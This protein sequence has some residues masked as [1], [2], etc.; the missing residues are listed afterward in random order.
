MNTYSNSESLLEDVSSEDLMNMNVVA[1]EPTPPPEG[2]EDYSIPNG[3][4]FD[5]AVQS[6]EQEFQDSQATGESLTEAFERIKQEYPDFEPDLASVTSWLEGFPQ[7]YPVDSQQQLVSPASAFENVPPAAQT[8]TPAERKALGHLVMQGVLAVTQASQLLEWLSARP[9]Y[10]SAGLY[11]NQNFIQNQGFENGLPVQNDQLYGMQGYNIENAFEIQGQDYNP[12]LSIGDHSVYQ[13]QMPTS[14]P[15]DNYSQDIHRETPNSDPAAL[16]FLNTPISCFQPEQ[17][18]LQQPDPQP[19]QQLDSLAQML[20][21]IVEFLNE[22]AVPSVFQGEEISANTLETV[23]MEEQVEQSV[24]A[25][26]NGAFF[27][28]ESGNAV[29]GQDQGVVDREVQSHPEEGIFS[30]LDEFGRNAEEREEDAAERE[31]SMW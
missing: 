2:F 22:E 1:Q 7:D 5:E 14:V 24:Y 31:M 15:K 30:G 8:T 3:E 11:P 13:M 23:T 17:Q 20:N 16:P 21:P 18:N 29:E 4:S 26:P 19:D 9:Y 25:E 27:G 6:V 12:D 10:H 28:F